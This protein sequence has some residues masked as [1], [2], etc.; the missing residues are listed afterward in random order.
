MLAPVKGTF[1]AYPGNGDAT[2]TLTSTT[3][4]PSIGYLV[5]GDF[6]RDGKLDFATSGNLLALAG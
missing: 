6:N 4:A 5:L 2:F 3:P 1:V